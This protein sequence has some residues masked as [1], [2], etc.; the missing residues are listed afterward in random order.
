LHNENS[1]NTGKLRQIIEG[2]LNRY[3]GRTL[4]NASEEEIFQAVALSLRDR[5]LERAAKAGEET[6]RRGMKT[7]YYLS[8]EFLL[9]RALVNNMVSLGA[10]DEYRA[11]LDEIG[12][13]FDRLEDQENEAGLGNGGLGRLAACFLDSL[14]TLNMPVIG[15][16]IRYEY[17][18]FR[19]RIVD[20]KQVEVPDDWTAKGDVWS[21]ERREEQVEVRFEGTV[22]E[23]WSEQGLTVHHRNYQSVLAVPYD[24]PVIGYDSKMPATLRLWSA[25]CPSFDLESFNKGDYGCMVQQRELAETISKVLYPED[26][27]I[28]GRMLRLKQYYF[29]A[30]ATMQHMVREHKKRYGDVRTLPDKVVVQINDTHP[31]FAIPE[32]M[33]ILLDEERLNW[34]EAYGIVSRIFSY[35]NHTVMREALEVWPEQMFKVLLPR[36]YSIVVALNDRFSDKLQKAFPGDWDKIAAMSIIAHDEVRMANMCLAVCSRINGVS[37]LHGD[38]LKTR[39]FRDFYVISPEKFVAITNGITQRRWLAAANPALCG[40]IHDYIGGGFL[41]DSRELERLKPL[42]DNPAFFADFARVK[43]QNKRCLAEYVKK[44]Q[45]VALNPDTVF[46][47]QAKRLHEYK[48]QLLKVLHILYLYNRLTEDVSFSL[49]QPVTFLFAAKA[50]PAYHRAKS[51][52]HLI[53]AVAA[54]V[55]SN[56]RTRDAIRVQFLENYNVTLA[57][58]LIPAADISEQLST[59]GREAS[60]T[61][62]MKFMLNGAVTLG[63]MDG[64]NVEIFERV[65]P[66][67]IFIFGAS[68][69]EIA[70]MER[71]RSYDPGK[72]FDSNPDVKAAVTRLIDGSLPGVDAGQFEDIYRSL[73]TGDYDPADRYFVL[74]DFDSYREVFDMVMRAYVDRAA[75]T[76][77]AALNTASA[78]F[79]SSDRTVAEYNRLIWHLESL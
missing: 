35:T 39:T 79:F 78:G 62:N 43:E 21:V 41:K 73:L 64:A 63:T 27:H 75:W 57:E 42:A 5:I 1:D 54:L 55:E 11:V 65:G 46:D 70:C 34:D 8:A 22:E 25:E 67:N 2:K 26:N 72:I 58:R 76:R 59:A 4:D 28:A 12:Y 56:P 37:Q 3:Y 19:Q 45:G 31:A 18:I 66:D 29:L 60:G 20:G 50:S 53:N 68:A 47:V 30:S 16:G 74:Y 77:R 38:I 61:G 9:G 13:P 17:G 40:L 51:I 52:I 15:S 23:V 48:R 24:M 7:L 32:L 10:L 69:E 44:T 71:D 6:A 33:R 36:V 14:S 49:P